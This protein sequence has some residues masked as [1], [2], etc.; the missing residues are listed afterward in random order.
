MKKLAVLFVFTPLFAMACTAKPT[1]DVAKP[2]VAHTKSTTA[3]VRQAGVW[4]DV[5]SADEYAKG[6]LA[7]TLNLPH[8][9]IG[10]QIAQSVPDKNTPIHVYCHSGRRAQ[11]A[12]NTLEAMGYTNVTNHGGY[13]ELVKQGLR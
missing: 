11:I 2:V 13:D 5:R 6:H 9:T 8:T 10:E 7:D 3:P 4:I 12:K 1:T